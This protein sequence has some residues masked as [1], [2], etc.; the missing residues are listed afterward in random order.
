M[1]RFM[2]LVLFFGGMLLLLGVSTRGISQES[3]KPL[4]QLTIHS[5]ADCYPTDLA[6][7]R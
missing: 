7:N 6:V 3:K 2:I 5:A 4:T 1:R